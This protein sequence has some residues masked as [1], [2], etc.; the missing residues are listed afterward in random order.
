MTS[1]ELNAWGLHGSGE[2]ATTGSL[3][4]WGLRV[5]AAPPLPAGPGAAPEA[6]ACEASSPLSLRQENHE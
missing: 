4:G 1:P 5:C 6:P 2:A 3:A